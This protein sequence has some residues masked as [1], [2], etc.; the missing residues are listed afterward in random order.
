MEALRVAGGW[1]S[2]I[3][4]HSAHRWRQG[5]RAGRFLPPGRFLALISV[6]GWVDPRAIVRLEELGKLKKSTSSGIRTGD[7]PACRTVPQPTTLPRAPVNNINV[8][9]K[10]ALLA[11]CFLLVNSEYRCNRFL[12]N[13]SSFLPNTRHYI[14]ENFLFVDI[15][16]RNMNST[17]VLLLSWLRLF[18]LVGG[19]WRFGRKYRLLPQDY[20]CRPDPSRVTSDG[21]SV[22]VGVEP[23]WCSQTQ[24]SFW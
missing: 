21:Q 2:H 22:L 6:R 15:A 7:R 23:S 5:W 19:Y 4:R 17:Y 9:L 3:F 14:R 10:S 11:A 18:T 12:W 1:G 20:T 8:D 16:V 13:V 24:F